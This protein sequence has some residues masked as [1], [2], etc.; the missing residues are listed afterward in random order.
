MVHSRN[1]TRLIL[2][3]VDASYRGA[4]DKKGWG[5]GGKGPG[6]GRNGMTAKTLVPGEVFK[7]SEQKLI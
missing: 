3:G 6:S 5:E 4:M 2:T 1:G 7:P